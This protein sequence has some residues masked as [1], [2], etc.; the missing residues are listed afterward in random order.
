MPV[1]VARYCVPGVYLWAGLTALA[2]AALCGWLA[3]SWPIC[4]FAS[5]LFVV[6]T[7][8][9]L[10]LASRPTVEL[11]ESYIKI[12]DS[13]FP[14][15]HIRRLDRSA[16]VPLVVRLTLTDKSRILLI[17]PGDPQTSSDLLRNLRR[18]SREALI[19]GVPYR[20]FWGEAALA[21]PRKQL[22]APRYPLL[23]PDDEAEVERMFQR[24]KSVGHLEE[25][26]PSEEK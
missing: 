9:V 15:Q 24:L 19:D 13:T 11:Y 16:K 8:L 1:P 21:G 22:A 10:Y 17:F 2:C 26:T 25:K 5:G 4:W 20:Q 23:L 12:G 7:I 14:W 3:L 6:S 18:Y